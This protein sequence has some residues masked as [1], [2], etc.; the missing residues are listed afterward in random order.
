MEF[1]DSKQIPL[2]AVLV[3]QGGKFLSRWIWNKGESTQ[4]LADRVAAIERTIAAGNEKSS[5]RASELTVYLEER[6]RV[7]D[8]I[9]T[10]VAMM[11]GELRARRESETSG[12]RDRRNP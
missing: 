6:R 10:T 3:I 1:Y 5:Q 9:K 2:Y 12:R 11:E 8:E 7:V 4:Q